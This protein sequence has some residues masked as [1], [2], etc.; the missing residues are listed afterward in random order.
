MKSVQG[1]RHAPPPHW[2]GD[3]FPVRTLFSYQSAG[4][5]P[6]PFLLLDYAAPSEFPPAEGRRGVGEHPHR[7]FE[8]V[9]LVYHGEVEHRDS[10]GNSGRI[11]PGD[12]QWMTAAGGVVHEEI[13]GGAFAET[14]GRMEMAQ[15]W[16]NLPA[17][18]KTSP[19]AYQTLVAAAIPVVVLPDGAGSLRVVA[20]EF[21]GTRGPARTFTPVEVWDLRLNP[22]GKLLARLPEG[23]TAVLAALQ[24]A[25]RV[26]GDTDLA[27]E[28]TAFLSRDGDRF[29]VEAPEGGKVL[30]LGG[31]P[32]P[33]PVVGYGPFVMNNEAEIHQAF[34][35]YRTGRMGHLPA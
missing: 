16:V 13:H 33:E 8:T 18:F 10:A 21:E 27:Q 24:G 25:F 17:R 28:E 3:G 31:Q 22:G 11:G 7:G 19:P 2:V 12:V 30:V 26:N 14:G 20:G 23:H 6:S 1:I 29:T 15:L 32:I 34:E 5:D 35:D 4:P 9:T